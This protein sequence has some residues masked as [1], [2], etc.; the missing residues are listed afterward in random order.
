MKAILTTGNSKT[1]TWPNALAKKKLPSPYDVEPPK[2]LCFLYARGLS[3]GIERV[4]T[5]IGIKAAFKSVR[6]LRQ[7]LMKVKSITLADRRK[8]VVY[9]VPARNAANLIL[10]R[11]R[12]L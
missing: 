6:T 10:E 5:C 4:C 12:G 7:C 2:I 11:T 1:L 3:K 8:G 9:K